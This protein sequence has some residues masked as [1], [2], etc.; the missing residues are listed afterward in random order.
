MDNKILISAEDN[1]LRLDRVIRARLP[2]LKQGQLEKFVRQGKIRLDAKK[3]KAGVRV[4][5]GQQIELK[6]DINSFLL[7][8]LF[9]VALYRR[10]FFFS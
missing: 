3:V 1:N 9:T 2:A 7:S 10:V 4:H 5:S 8:Y 6:F